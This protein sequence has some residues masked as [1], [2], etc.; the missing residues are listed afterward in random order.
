MLSKRLRMLAKRAGTGEYLTERFRQM[1]EERQNQ[2]QNERAFAKEEAK[3]VISLPVHIT[4]ELARIF[5]EWEEMEEK[6]GVRSDEEH[7]FLLEVM[8][9][10]IGIRSP[11]DSDILKFF[12]HP[13]YRKVEP[14]EYYTTDALDRPMRPGEIRGSVIP[15]DSSGLARIMFDAEDE[16]WWNLIHQKAH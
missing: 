13:S 7:D 11:S 3:K 15:F 10:A 2:L 12:G 4:S 16:L 1:D 5:I 6:Y 9:P 14:G 8:G